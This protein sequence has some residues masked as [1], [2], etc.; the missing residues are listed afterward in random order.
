MTPDELVAHYRRYA[1]ECLAI[2]KD[3]PD[4]RG[5]LGLLDMAQAWLALADQAEKSGKTVMGYKTRE[6]RQVAQQQQ[7]QHEES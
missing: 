1:A 3:T 4:R 5:K 6:P 7:P 2:A